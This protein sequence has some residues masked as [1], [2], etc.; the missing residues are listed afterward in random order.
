[1]D[2]TL[3]KTIRGFSQYVNEIKPD[4][5]VVHGDR[6]E[7]LSGAIVGSFNNILVSHIEGGEL[8]GTID[9]SIRHSV[10]K[11]SHLH[12]VSNQDSKKRLMKMG[13]VSYTHLRA[14]E[15]DS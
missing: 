13:A 12:F 15:T 8:S 7:A 2:L 3:S 9:E 5:I 14:H 6:P 4:M 10:S 1:M 11:L